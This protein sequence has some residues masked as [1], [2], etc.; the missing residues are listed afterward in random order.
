M[1]KLEN[2]RFLGDAPEFSET[3][4]AGITATVTYPTECDGWDAVVGNSYGGSIT[5]KKAPNAFEASLEEDV[6]II[7]PNG[8]A[9]IRPVIFPDQCEVNCVWSSSDTSVVTVDQNGKVSAVGSGPALINVQLTDGT[10]TVKLSQMVYV[11]GNAKFTLPSALESIEFDAF[12]NIAANDIFL[13]ESVV[14]I[15]ECA[16]ADRSKPIAIHIPD[17]VE[18]IAY[19]AFY[20]CKY[21]IVFGS[22]GSYAQDFATEHGYFFVAE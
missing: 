14:K 8:S 22:V 17:S 18:Y 6:V 15:R 7:K 21:V 4:F 20:G 1:S 19:G 13:G 3:A 2:I 11:A 9:V 10:T 5:W 16:F 12:A